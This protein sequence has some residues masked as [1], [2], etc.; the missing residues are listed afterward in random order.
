MDL[1]DWT[2]HHSNA[3]D[4]YTFREGF[5]LA[6]GDIAVVVTGDDDNDELTQDGYVSVGF[7]LSEKDTIVLKDTTGLIR[8]QETWG[9]ASLELP[10]AKRP[11][12]G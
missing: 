4:V 7:Q 5:S 8:D 11:R 3:D 12:P 10:A 1:E 9:R 2:L 6:P